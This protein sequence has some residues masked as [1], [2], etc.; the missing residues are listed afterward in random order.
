MAN[1]ISPS[2]DGT[3]LDLF[4]DDS[5]E[6]DPAHS[7]VYT[8]TVDSTTD[9]DITLAWVDSEA[10]TLSNHTAVKLVNDLDLSATAP[11]GT[12][13]LGNVF[14]SGF[15]TIGGAADRLNN[16]ERIKVPA[17]DSGLWTITIGHAGGMSQ[18]FSLVATGLLAEENTADLAVFEGSLSTSIL[19]PLQGDTILVEAA[20]RNQAGQASGAYPIEVEDL[21]EGTILYTSD[22][23]SLAGGATTS[24]S[25]PHV[26]QTTGDHILELRLDTGDSVT[27]I[28][29]ETNGLDNNRYQ[30]TVEI[31]Q[32]GVR[33]TPLMED[34]SLPETPL[35]LDP[36]KHRVFE[37]VCID[38][39][40]SA[41][42]DHVEVKDTGRM[43]VEKHQNGTKP[44]SDCTMHH[45]RQNQGER[46]NEDR[47]NDLGIGNH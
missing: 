13:Y 28:N 38:Q 4:Y 40:S 6:L 41:I 3:D 7:F 19:A 33:I 35:E 31:S 14:A 10:S 26:F 8:F 17:G 43:T 21:T 30:L 47:E 32:I 46:E 39:I 24:L 25:F 15:S 34:G 18:G 9:L 11:D 36:T 22:R 23:A 2:H 45:L 37:R 29:D 12:V 27:E 1:S 44:G 16:V 42:V 20:W 5:R